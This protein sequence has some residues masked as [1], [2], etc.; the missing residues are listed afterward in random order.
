MI[1]PY[2][3][4]SNGVGEIYELLN[5]FNKFE[6]GSLSTRIAR[7]LYHYKTI[8]Q[9]SINKTLAE[10]LFNRKFLSLLDVF[11]PEIIWSKN[12][13]SNNS[14]FVIDE[15][16]FAKNF[17]K[18]PERLAGTVVAIVNSLNYK[19]KFDCDT[20]VICLRHASQLFTRELAYSENQDVLTLVVDK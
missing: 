13:S 9:A 1:A 20:S 12:I 2:H 18:S 11:K 6:K 10:V 19:I 3:P 16:V 15:A 7:L 17:G 14:K 8:V 4:Q 5:L